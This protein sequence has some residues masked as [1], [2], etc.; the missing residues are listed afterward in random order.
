MHNLKIE[1]SDVSYDTLSSVITFLYTGDT[2][3][4]AENCL[5]LLLASNL[6]QIPGLNDAATRK[7][8]A[9]LESG[10]VMD[11]LRIAQVH[12][13]DRLYKNCLI[14]ITLHYDPRKHWNL[15][16]DEEDYI[17]DLLNKLNKS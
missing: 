10:S 4:T 9:N 8:T 2:V 14:Y 5:D 12:N 7:I 16:D 15:Q 6:F 13:I 11:I 1:L 17:I 3:I